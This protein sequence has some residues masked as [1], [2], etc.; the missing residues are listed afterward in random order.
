VIVPK[1]NARDLDD[2]PDEICKVMQFVLVDH[3]DEAIH[4]GLLPVDARTEGT[5][6]Q[7]Q[8]DRT[9]K[10]MDEEVVA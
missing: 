7:H 3:I 8:T 9:L 10:Q 1:R 5:G 2:V 6:V 4:T